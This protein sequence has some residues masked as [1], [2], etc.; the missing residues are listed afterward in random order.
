L[1]HFLSQVVV[2]VVQGCQTGYV[3]QDV[4]PNGSLVKRDRSSSDADL[5]PFLSGAGS[6][7]GSDRELSRLGL[8][9]ITS[10]DLTAIAVAQ[11]IYL[12]IIT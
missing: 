3:Y 2:L 7:G 9:S 12:L 11:L 1:F 5:A 6:F 4:A 8:D 10:V